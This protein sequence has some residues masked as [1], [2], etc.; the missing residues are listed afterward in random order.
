[1]PEHFRIYYQLHRDKFQA[2]KIAGRAQANGI[3]VIPGACEQCGRTG[4]R[5]EKHHEDYSKPLEVKWLCRACH[6]LLNRK[7]KQQ[8]GSNL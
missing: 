1:M 7:D 3:L 2:R 6:A 4:T 5:L 8:N